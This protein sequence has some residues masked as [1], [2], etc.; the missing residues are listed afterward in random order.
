MFFYSFTHNLRDISPLYY[1]H[2]FNHLIYFMV[3][4]ILKLREQDG[5]VKFSANGSS[6]GNPGESG[7]GFLI[8]DS[9]GMLL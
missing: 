1:D 2:L 7:G 6:I 4:A 3:G 8:R 5:F 9:S